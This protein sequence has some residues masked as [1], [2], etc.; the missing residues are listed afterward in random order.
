MDNRRPLIQPGTAK[1]TEVF[2][3][4]VEQSRSGT[5]HLHAENLSTKEDC[6]M[7]EISS[8][9]RLPCRPDKLWSI[10]SDPNTLSEWVPTARITE[11]EG[12][13]EVH[14]LGESHGHPYD[15][16]AHLHA[17][18]SA[19]RLE[20]EADNSGYRGSLQ[21][22]GE[23]DATKVEVRITIPEDRVPSS[24]ETFDEI[25][26]GMDEALARLAKLAE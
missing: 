26:R 9:R 20:W 22:D 4:A 3:A 18:S 7:V 25:R 24:E 12:P 13:E 21:I 17:D 10:V 5:R 1:T 15:L 23:A 6:Q 14:L 2:Q 19:R 16:Q 11:P 8:L